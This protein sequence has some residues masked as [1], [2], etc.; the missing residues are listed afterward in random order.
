MKKA[1]ALTMMMA[2]MMPSCT[3]GS[4]SLTNEERQGSSSATGGKITVTV[5]GKT[6]TATLVDNATAL[7]FKNLLPMTLGMSELNGNEKY[8]YLSNSLPSNA[9]NPGTIHAGDIMLYGW[10]CVVVFYKTFS[11]SYRYTRIGR[12]DDATGLE[13]ALGSGSASV[14]F[15]IQTTGIAS[16]KTA[17][18]D[19]DGT[20]YDLQ[21]M[22]VS[23][24]KDGIF[25]HNGKKV[26]L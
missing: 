2:A 20:Y 10:G 11:T 9:T 8:N 13:E 18:S 21:G 23:N 24:P 22:R 6:F 3:K 14:A 19:E 12:I 7:A 17:Q 26:R 4:D 25:I 5:G 16:A 15:G 1:I